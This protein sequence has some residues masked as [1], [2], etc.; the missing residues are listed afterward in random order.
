L[1]LCRTLTQGAIDAR[2]APDRW[3]PI[4]LQFEGLRFNVRPPLSGYYPFEPSAGQNHEWLLK[5]AFQPFGLSIFEVE[6]DVAR[7][8]F[9]V[10]HVNAL[11]ANVLSWIRVLTRQ[12]WLGKQARPAG[13]VPSYEL[14]EDGQTLHSGGGVN[15][16]KYGRPLERSDW[17]ALG[18]CNTGAALPDIALVTF[19]D[20]LLSYGNGDRRHS[21][22]QMASCCDQEV[23]YLVERAYTSKAPSLAA[24]IKKRLRYEFSTA[25]SELVHALGL[26]PFN[27]FD[28]KAAKKINELYDYRG[29][30]IHQK[31]LAFI[32]PDPMSFAWAVEKLFSWSEAQANRL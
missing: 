20:S 26:Q 6:V 3:R 31:N 15:V 11:I 23:N 28:A 22:I 7:E 16:L 24:F 13:L 32:M 29:R 8:E 14:F 30:A 5:A 27:E 4:D 17:D 18:I 9:D 21:L 2:E 1:I 25:H 12:F 19:C 10:A